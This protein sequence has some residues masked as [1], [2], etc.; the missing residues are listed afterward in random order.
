MPSDLPQFTIR[1]NKLTLYKIRY[2][3]EAQG[4]SANREIAMLIK[5]YISAYE[6]KHGAIQVP[7]EKS[8][9]SDD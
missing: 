6:S 7:A 8:S 5:R 2:I 3:A 1:V 4:R 9:L